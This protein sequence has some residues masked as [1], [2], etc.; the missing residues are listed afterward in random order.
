M[1]SIDVVWLLKLLK[2]TSVLLIIV[3]LLCSISVNSQDQKCQKW[4]SSWFIDNTNVPGIFNT[5]QTTCKTIE[6]LHNQ[7]N[8]SNIILKP[9]LVDSD[10]WMCDEYFIDKKDGM[11]KFK[12]TFTSVTRVQRNLICENFMFGP[13]SML[14]DAW[15]MRVRTKKIGGSNFEVPMGF[16]LRGEPFDGTQRMAIL[17]QNSPN[18]GISYVSDL[19]SIP[20][21][22]D[23]D[24][25]DCGGKLTL[26]HKDEN[27]RPEIHH[28]LPAKDDRGCDCGRNSYKNALVISR[29]LN[30][31]ILNN[32]NDKRLLRILEYFAI[33]PT[34][35]ETEVVEVN[36]ALKLPKVKKR[37]KKTKTKAKR[38]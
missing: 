20:E 12:S 15:T 37:V 31:D 22:A 23:I 1:K 30:Q 18:G 28:I 16:R 29:K 3:V 10:L 21:L 8:N 19:W 13:Y 36:T 35:T 2:K 11:E 5:P 7:M 24:N 38:K 6:S 17:E 26:N 9:R 32:F 25:Y 4:T 27:C 33:M 14:S 34:F